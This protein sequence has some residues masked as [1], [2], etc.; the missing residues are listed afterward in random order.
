MLNIAKRQQQEYYELLPEWTRY[1]KDEYK[2]LKQNI[3]FAIFGPPSEMTDVALRN[4][5][6]QYYSNIFDY[7]SEIKK[8]IDIIYDKILEFGEVDIKAETCTKAVYYGLIY[9][10]TFRTK[11]SSVTN[12]STEEK[13]TK[14]KSIKE[15]NE[16]EN[17]ININL[18]PIFKI[19]SSKCEEQQTWYIDTEGRVY[20]NW[21]WY[22]EN[23]TLQA[24]TMVLPKDGFYQPDENFEITEEY[25]TVWLEILDSPAC[26]TLQTILNMGDRASSILGVVGLGLGVA[27]MLTPVGPAVLGKLDKVYFIVINMYKCFSVY[28]SNLYDIIILF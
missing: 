17:K 20:K 21:M 6:N 27:S 2:Y 18:R 23:N 19:K 5:N 12:K 3:G 25:S 14:E 13:S 10:I 9:N 24:C 11:E 28:L 26:S 7:P 8:I 4:T 1:T 22:K 16:E 15:K